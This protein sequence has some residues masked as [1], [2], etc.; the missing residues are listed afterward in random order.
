MRART[1]TQSILGFLFT[2]ALLLLVSTSYGEGKEKVRLSVD[3]YHIMDQESYLSI[4]AKYKVEKKYQ[5]A[6]ELSIS[7]YEEIEDSLVL[8]GTCETGFDG[9]A[10]FS[11]PL[12]KRPSLDTLL[13]KV[14]KITV[15]DN[16]FFKDAS[17]S[18]NFIQSFLSGG[19]VTEDS[20]IYAVGRLTDGNGNPIEGQKIKLQVQRLFAPLQIGESYYKTDDDGTIKVEIGKPL[21]G[22]DGILTFEFVAD[23]RK[24]GNLVSIFEAEVG[25]EIVDLSTFDNRT[26][27]SP[28]NK[29]PLFLLIFPNILILG[30]I[31]VMVIIIKNLYTI[32]KS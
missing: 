13:P 14:Y 23:L 8:I 9:N 20:L 10:I 25:T 15:E 24:Y 2:L 31:I 1:N 3:Y 19:I 16:Y 7:I 28:N 6:T 30:I 11:L 12:M 22:H 32:Y 5:A 29:T 4:D 18:I 21:P 17:K 27:W 26:M